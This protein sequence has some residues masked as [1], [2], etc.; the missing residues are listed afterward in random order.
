MSAI[1]PLL[2]GKQTSEERV[3][4]D[5]IDPT[6]TSLDVRLLL[7]IREVRRPSQHAGAASRRHPGRSDRL[8][9]FLF[10]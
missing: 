4:N 7:V 8:D 1:P 9:G 6:R 2:G 5:A 3:K 10:A